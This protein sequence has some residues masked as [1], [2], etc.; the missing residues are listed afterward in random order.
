MKAKQTDKHGE[1]KK[2][3]NRKA[4]LE[5]DKGDLYIL[6]NKY[7]RK[8][9]EKQQKNICRKIINFK[10]L[11]KKKTLKIVRDHHRCRCI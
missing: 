6:K 2:R 7:D 3:K 9:L 4:K 5:V 11:K 10:K 1:K 8:E